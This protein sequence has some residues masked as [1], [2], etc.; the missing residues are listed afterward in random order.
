MS[1][2]CMGDWAGSIFFIVLVIGAVVGLKALSKQK[3]RTAE[4]LNEMSPKADRSRRNDERP[5][6]N[7]KSRRGKGKEVVMQM[8]EGDRKKRLAET[9]RT[10]GT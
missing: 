10:D 4:S 2:R 6:G 1:I 9:R 5:S 8:K 7:A 3:T